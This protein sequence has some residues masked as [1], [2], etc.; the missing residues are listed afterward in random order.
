MVEDVTT[1][2]ATLTSRLQ[3]QFQLFV[4]AMGEAVVVMPP[5]LQAKVAG[6]CLLRRPSSTRT[7]SPVTMEE[8]GRAQRAPVVMAMTRVAVVF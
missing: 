2:I 6:L 1:I 4:I 7:V 5:V 8:T 3:T